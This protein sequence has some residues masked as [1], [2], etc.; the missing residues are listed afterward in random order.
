[1]RIELVRLRRELNTTMIYVTHDQVEAMT[2]ADRIVVLNDGKVEQVGSPLELY[3][4]PATVFVAGF[5][6]APRMNLLTPRG[7][8]RRGEART[9]GVR[10][11]HV[12][13][14]NDGELGGEIVALENL[15]PR[16]YVHAR[17]DD[18]DGLI[19]QTEGDARVRE[20]ER[21]RFHVSA[22]SCHWFDASGRRLA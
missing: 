13:I 9:V 21:L 7:Q 4:H 20:G 15:G 19:V 22:E 11:E 14:D 1:M 12:R 6:G 10:P 2:M 18:G 3:H 5:I 16:T 17:L 8:L